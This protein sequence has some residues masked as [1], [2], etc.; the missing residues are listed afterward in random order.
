M[1]R[2]KIAL[3]V[4]LLTAG[5]VV[6]A[7]AAQAAGT[8]HLHFEYGPVHVLRGQNV[9]QNSGSIPKP[10]QDGWITG[11]R[12]NLILPDGTVPP[13]DVIHLHHVVFLNTSRSD[14]TRPGLPERFFAVGEEKTRLKLPKPYGYPTKASDHWALNYM[15]H[16]LVNREF[17]VRIVYDI[18][19]VPANTSKPLHN[20]TPI[21]MDVQNGS[22]YPVFDVHLHGGT[23]G[24][25]TY[26][27]DATNPYSGA[28][29]NEW[30]LPS[31][32]R[33]VLTGGHLHPGGLWTDLYLER[34]S[35]TAHLFRSTAKYYEKA[36]PVSWDVSIN[37]TTPKWNVGVQAGD[38]LR[39][40]ATY[41]SSQWAWF[42]TMGIMQVWFAPNE[43][44]TD[45]FALST[46]Q[47]KGKL[48]HGHL[49][50]NNNHGGADDPTLP[51]AT[52]LPDG[53]AT[54]TV[55]ITNF[56]YQPGNLLH[57]TAVPTVHA[58]DSITFDNLDA[59]ASGYGTWHSITA[60]KLP[61][62][63]TTGVAYPT[64]NADVEFDSGQLGN[65]GP[66]TAGRLT[67]NTPT[68]LAPG[69]YSYFCRVHPF[70]RGVFRVVP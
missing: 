26:P 39:I 40:T 47:M 7:P 60:C 3:L 13:V 11:F 32:G 69:T 52:A 57:A 46:S 50:E 21:W 23:N 67:W 17:D 19:F 41:D 36:G 56:L 5:L 8:Q 14:T 22:A 24:K 29:L 33:L 38:V 54:T 66:P 4:T 53:S 31:A 61:C 45:P 12:P 42:E 43:T 15:L 10:A 6:I 27:D 35:Q 59:P 16:D 1:G 18:D 48:T 55:D 63:K 30:T 20:V 34:G 58:G 28:P 62:D 49:K 64:A 37:V 70:M 44:G 65:N 68:N 51:D 25:F 9:I 2:Y